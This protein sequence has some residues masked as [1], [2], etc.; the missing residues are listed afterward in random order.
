MHHASMVT[1]G[2]D[3]D[4][5]PGRAGRQGSEYRRSAMPAAD[6]PPPAWW[7][8]QLTLP[9]RWVVGVTWGAVCAGYGAL[10]DLGDYLGKLPAWWDWRWVAALV[11]LATIVTVVLDRGGALLLSLASTVLVAALALVDL[12]ADRTG[13]AAVEGVLAVAGLLV[14]LAALSGQRGE[15]AGLPPPRA[16]DIVGVTPP[17]VV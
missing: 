5:E 13:L 11:P 14:T 8:A 17:Q 2:W 7:R 4:P 10:L 16:E 12:A 6:R 9:W 3:T 1:D 15:P